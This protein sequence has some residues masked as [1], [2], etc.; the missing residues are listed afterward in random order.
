MSSLYKLDSEWDCLQAMIEDGDTTEEEM[1]DHLEAMGI[2]FADKAQAIG[3]VIANMDSERAILQAEVMRL[4]GR[5]DKLSDDA[6]K[7]SG[8]LL[9]SMIKRGEKKVKTPLFTMSWRKPTQKAVVDDESIIPG[10]Y[11]VTVPAV[12]A[13]SKLDKRLLLKGLKA[14]DIEGAH[15]EDGTINLSIK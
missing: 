5:A 8:Y 14:G 15:L 10:S 12:K 11:Y 6:Q 13:Y 3:C 7:L 1:T 2:E 4:E 9:K